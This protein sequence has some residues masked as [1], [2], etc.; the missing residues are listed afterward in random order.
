LENVIMAK[1]GSEEG[2]RVDYDPQLVE[3]CV[4][5]CIGRDREHRRLRR[6]RDI[7]YD[8]Q[9][10]DERERQ[11]QK[12]HAECFRL[13]Q[14]EQPIMR[15]LK[16]QPGLMERTAR[17]CVVSARSAADEGADLHELRDGAAQGTLSAKVIVI[18][19]KPE[20][21][22]DSYSQSWLRHELMHVVDMLDPAF[23]Y[24]RTAFSSN[25]GTPLVNLQ[26]DRYKA[27]WNTWIDGRLVRRG[28]LPDNVRAKCCQEFIRVFPGPRADCERMFDE[29]F[30][31]DHRTHAELMAIASCPP[32]LDDNGPR[33]RSC[34]ICLFPSF[35][36]IPGA[37]VT[38][39][40]RQEI[41]KDYPNW[42]PEHRIC[43]QCA[44][45]FSARILS[46][47]AEAALPRV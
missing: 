32:S 26:R 42:R 46:R 1:A 8:V 3:A 17:C 20:R 14:M 11:F 30:S 41:A 24:E 19:L 4:L 31:A 15:A 18:H 43:R 7:I 47:A 10:A 25:D 12:F 2:F 36:M 9:D 45:L 39:E 29:L 38:P 13:L 23:G 6:A 27:L 40:A 21:L 16:E 22:V 35:A 34:P 5:L 33:A 37:D 28:W 44:D